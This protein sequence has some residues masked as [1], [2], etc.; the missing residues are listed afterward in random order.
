MPFGPFLAGGG[1]V[2]MF[3]GAH[4]A[5]LLDWLECLTTLD[6]PDSRIGLTGGIGS[7]KSTV[8]A[9]LVALRRRARRHRRHRAPA[10]RA[11]RRRD[12]RAVARAS[13]PTSSLPTA[14]STAT[15]CAR[16]RSPIRRRKRRLEAILHPL[17]GAEA[18]APG[19]PRPA[20]R[21]VVFDVPLLA[22][23]QRWRSRVD[24]VLVVD[25]ARGHAGR[26]A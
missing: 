15:R 26:S 5:R 9:M 1:L 25:C 17:I 14:P 11:R 23:S 16:W 19:R 21:P 3:V 12:A 8:A 22:E 2:V 10:D 6:T 20:S 4:G 24:R 7:G 18:A 13:A